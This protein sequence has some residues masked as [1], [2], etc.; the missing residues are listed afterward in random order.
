LNLI[1]IKFPDVL[2]SDFFQSNSVLFD[3]RGNLEGV[4]FCFIY[5]IHS[6]R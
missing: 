2:T 6:I 4:K 1:E 5:L 3:F